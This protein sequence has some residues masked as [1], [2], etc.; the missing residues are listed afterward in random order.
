V[1]FHLYSGHA[2]TPK[3]GVPFPLSGRGF[4]H[5]GRGLKA[6]PL[7]AGSGVPAPFWPYPDPK[8]GR[9]L[10]PKWACSYPKWAWLPQRGAWPESPPPSGRKWRFIPIWP[11]PNPKGGGF[12]SP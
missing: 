10:P 6:R 3:W 12:P 5:G 1:K 4:H 8:G 11:Y 9:F 7:A 2:P